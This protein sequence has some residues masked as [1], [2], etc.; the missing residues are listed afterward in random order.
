[1]FDK[2][3]PLATSLIL[4]SACQ[5]APPMS[6]ATFDKAAAQ[7]GLRQTTYTHRDGFFLDEPLIDFSRE[8]NPHKANE[9]FGEALEKLDMEMTANG[10]DHISYIWEW[11]E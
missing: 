10:A 7:C 1:M 6:Q 3:L 5:S 9:C 11:R 4:I 2:R 8:A